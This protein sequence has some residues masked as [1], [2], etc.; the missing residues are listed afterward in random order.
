MV[1]R[2]LKA[3]GT[4]GTGDRRHKGQKTESR[5]L[6]STPHL[7]TH[8]QMLSGNAHTVHTA[9]HAAVHA[10]VHMAVHT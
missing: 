1:P 2:E 6:V 4:E 10:A 8:I 3:Q 7:L 9:V 5:E